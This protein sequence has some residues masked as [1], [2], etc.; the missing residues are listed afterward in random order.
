MAELKTGGFLSNNIQLISLVEYLVSW[1]KKKNDNK[2][3]FYLYDFIILISKNSDINIKKEL[4]IE[5]ASYILKLYNKTIKKINNQERESLIKA[6]IEYL[7]DEM[8]NKED[9]KKV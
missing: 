9:Y 5:S 4:R 1:C 8:F 3:F 7:K 2:I 6:I